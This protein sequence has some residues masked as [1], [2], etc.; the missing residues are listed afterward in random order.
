MVPIGLQLYTV[1]EAMQADPVGTLRRVAEL[2]FQGVELAGTAGM[3]P[4]QFR[5]V[6]DDLGLV[7]ISA[8]MGLSPEGLSAETLE[9]ATQVGTP[10]LVVNAWPD[11]F[12]SAAA[13]EAVA[14]R[15]NA[16]AAQARAAGIELGYHNH[17]WELAPSAAGEYPYLEFASR[18]DDAFFEL[19]IYW[20]HAACPATAWRAVA[21]AVADRVRTVHVKDGPGTLPDANWRTDP[22]TPAGTGVV[23]VPAMLAALPRAEWHVVEF[24]EC[25]TDIFEA[26]AASRRF[27]LDHCG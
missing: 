11:D 2:G 19:D 7:V 8:M 9:F 22:M 21:S 15:F 17:W 13:I 27:L 12:A 6:L 14:A 4:A 1:R 3:E 20:L 16:G 24:D 23:D 5:R 18:L 26:V 25:A 10:R